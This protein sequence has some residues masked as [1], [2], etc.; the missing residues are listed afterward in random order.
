MAEGDLFSARSDGIQALGLGYRP[1]SWNSVF[2]R[3]GHVAAA[4]SGYDEHR[5]GV[6]AGDAGGDLVVAWCFRMQAKGAVS[7]SVRAGAVCGPRAD[8][9]RRRRSG[10][11][12]LRRDTTCKWRPRRM[13][14]VMELGASTRD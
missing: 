7:S 12:R 6:R 8:M 5:D 11:C 9:H 10:S 14:S 13:L 2:V 4:T 3:P 1:G